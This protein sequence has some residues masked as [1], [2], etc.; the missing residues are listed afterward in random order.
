MIWPSRES[1]SPFLP[2]EVALFSDSFLMQKLIAGGRLAELST[3]MQFFIRWIFIQYTKSWFNGSTFV[4]AKSWTN[5]QVEPLTMQIYY[6]R[7]Q[8][9]PI[10]PATFWTN[11]QFWTIIHGTIN[12]KFGVFVIALYVN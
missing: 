10:Q 2:R 5:W 6:A 4:Q 3:A 9:V 11:K 7:D 12:P 8:F 1:L